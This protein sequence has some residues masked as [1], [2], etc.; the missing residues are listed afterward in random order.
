VPSLVDELDVASE[1]GIA[2]FLTSRRLNST[3]AQPDHDVLWWSHQPIPSFSW[4]YY[5]HNDDGTSQWTFTL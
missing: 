3:V 1:G 4:H 5:E 2:I